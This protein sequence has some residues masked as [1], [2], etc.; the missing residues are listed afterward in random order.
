[1]LS[2]VD[3]AVGEVERDIAAAKGGDADAAQKAKRALLEADATLEE[4]EV[5]SKWPELEEDAREAVT[6][7]SSWVSQYGTPQEQRLFEESAAGVERARRARQVVELQRRVRQVRQL[8]WAA[9]FRNPEAWNI[10][11]E[12]AASDSHRAKDPKRFQQLVE[13]GRRARERGDNA[14]VRSVTEQLWRLLPVDTTQLRE[15]HG[16]GLR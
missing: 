13:D 10:Q 8:R 15:G 16:S 1:M 5:E 4:C 3:Q 11:L 2:Q 9:Y 6:N 14:T 7:A 12:E